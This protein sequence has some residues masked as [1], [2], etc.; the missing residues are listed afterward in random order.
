MIWVDRFW[1]PEQ[2]SLYKIAI[3][4]RDDSDIHY[5]L[6]DDSSDVHL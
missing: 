3:D 6:Y 2:A 4:A 5:V 1:N